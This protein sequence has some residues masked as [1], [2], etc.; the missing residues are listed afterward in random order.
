MDAGFRRVRAGCGEALRSQGGGD[1]AGQQRSNHQA[2]YRARAHPLGGTH[3]STPPFRTAVR[4]RA[5]GRRTFNG[6]LKGHWVCIQ[7]A[8]IGFIFFRF[9]LDEQ[10]LVSRWLLDYGDRRLVL[11]QIE[12]D[13]SARM[14]FKQLSLLQTILPCKGSIAGNPRIEPTPY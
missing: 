13:P 8:V 2:A 3:T 6:M 12:D 1:S 14:A 5:E 4:W 9:C 10:R 7:I 11:S